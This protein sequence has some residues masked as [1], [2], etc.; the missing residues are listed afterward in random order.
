MAGLM[1]VL[2]AC[3]GGG[4]GNQPTANI[5]NEKPVVDDKPINDKKPVLF[6]NSD[7]VY[8]YV[9][10][11]NAQTT[12]KITYYQREDLLYVKSS[13][14][15][16][17]YS[18]YILTNNELYEPETPATLVAGQDIRDSFIHAV[19]K[20]KWLITPYNQQG[21]KSLKITEV[22]EKLDLNGKPIA[23]VLAPVDAVLALQSQQKNSPVNI[24][25]NSL[26]SKILANQVV[27]PKGAQCLQPVSTDYSE[28]ALE[29]N[30]DD[31]TSVIPN[32]KNLQDW[33][34][35]AFD[36]GISA[37]NLVEKHSWAGVNWG[38]ITLKDYDSQGNIQYLFAIEYQGKVY[39]A[40][41]RGGKLTFSELMTIYRQQLLAQQ[42][43]P[44]LVN[45]MIA[46]LK[47]SCFAYNE[48]AATAIDQ[49]I[50]QAKKQL[51]D[52]PPVI[53]PPIENLPPETLPTAPNCYGNLVFC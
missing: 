39:Q 15:G 3:G 17:G 23:P 46:N 35:L 10:G 50:E 45:T 11:I 38:A 8:R 42:F 18:P 41:P 44:E 13:Q 28:N 19:E 22:F 37:S 53:L 47:N 51:S 14:A 24:F 33:A 27:F 31:V 9:L 7:T 6:D 5:P 16:K 25:Q 1:V 21:N 2:S 40:Q 32:A 48:T 29:F 34:N 30:P 26:I 12:E 43:T 36:I 49:A 4:S 20:N 52:L